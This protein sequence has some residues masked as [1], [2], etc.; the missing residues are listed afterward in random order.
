M[1]AWRKDK[2]WVWRRA[3]DA[4]RGHGWHASVRG[5]FQEYSFRAISPGSVRMLKSAAATRRGPRG[6]RSP[7]ERSRNRQ[8]LS[9]PVSVP[10]PE[11]QLMIS[12]CRSDR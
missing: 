11:P 7:L 1:V 10:P 9:L 2:R 3:A 12:R 5:K 8:G 4:R 6:H